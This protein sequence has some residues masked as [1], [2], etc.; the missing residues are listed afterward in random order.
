MRSG[1]LWEGGGWDVIMMAP[2]E[3]GGREG[4]R[5]GVFFFFFEISWV[6]TS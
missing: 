3:D 5:G 1:F 6:R 4:W 2:S